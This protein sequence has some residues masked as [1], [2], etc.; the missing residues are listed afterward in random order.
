[1]DREFP[2]D[3]LAEAARTPGG[4]VYEIDADQV[5]DPNGAVPPEAIGGAWA[6]GLDGKPT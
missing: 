4:W 3:L 1:M 2:Q 6:V 5:A